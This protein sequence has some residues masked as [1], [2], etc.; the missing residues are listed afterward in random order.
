MIQWRQPKVCG[1]KARKALATLHRFRLRWVLLMDEGL[2][3]N[4]R[5]VMGSGMLIVDA[6]AVRM[7]NLLETEVH[8]GNERHRG[9]VSEREREH[10]RTWLRDFR[11]SCS[12]RGQIHLSACKENPAALGIRRVPDMVTLEDAGC[13]NPGIRSN[14]GVQRGLMEEICR[15]CYALPIDVGHSVLEAMR[16]PSPF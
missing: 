6:A 2:S 9:E 7:L 5:R 10:I 12:P 15:R 13:S 8:G 4:H 11:P 1:P 14:V 16:C 3:E